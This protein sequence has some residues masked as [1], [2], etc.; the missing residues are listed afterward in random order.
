MNLIFAS[1]NNHKAQEIASALPL[2]FSIQTLK[3]LGYNHEIPETG[4]TLEENARIKAKTVFDLFG[5]PC[6]ADDTGLEVLELNG[7]PGVYSARYA[8]PNASFSDNCSLLL[9]SLEGIVNRSAKF[10][11]VFCFIDT[12]GK[13]FLFTG[14]VN[15]IITLN[16]TGQEGF[17]YD[18]VFQPDGFNKTFA[19]MTLDEKNAISHRGKAVK[20]FTQFFESHN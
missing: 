13:E 1:Q 15:G 12:S 7:A 2:G 6:F 16:Y 9:K 19:E 20:V 3:E 8:G 18:P 4:N 17:G 11:T 10:R 5:K 14:E